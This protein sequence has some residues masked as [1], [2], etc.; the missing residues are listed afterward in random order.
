MTIS[1][2]MLVKNEAHCIDKAI[3][4]AKPF[5]NE[6]I[7]IDDS[8]TDKTPVI[9]QSNGA[10]VFTLPQPIK[11][12]GFGNGINFAIEKAS[13]EWILLIDADE[14]I[15]EHTLHQL[16]RFPEVNAWALPRRKWLNLTSREEYEAYPDWQ[17]RLFR[18]KP[19]NRFKGEMHVRFQ[20]GGVKYAYR[21]PH[22]EHYQFIFRTPEKLA[23]RADLYK[24]LADIQ[25]VSVEGGHVL[26]RKN[27]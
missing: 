9:A 2:I 19:E 14:E 20:G 24:G 27:D 15:Q 25:N 11:E 6:I 26:E 3:R 21:G 1:L 7:V 12:I 10:K 23:Q 22:V 4:S 17:I 18:N 13:M 16:L 5:V 8:S